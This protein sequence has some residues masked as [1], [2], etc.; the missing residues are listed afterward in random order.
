LILSIVGEEAT[1]EMLVKIFAQ[2][3]VNL[4]PVDLVVIFED[5]VKGKRLFCS[6]DY[7]IL[8]SYNKNNSVIKEVFIEN[9]Y[10]TVLRVFILEVDFVI[11]N[12]NSLVDI[13]C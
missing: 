5:S 1:E 4:Q 7:G 6:Q 9:S 2:Q 8:N 11:N 10:E 3:R 12:E 13:M